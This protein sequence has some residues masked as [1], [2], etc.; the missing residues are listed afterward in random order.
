LGG[1]AK[2]IFRLAIARHD[3]PWNI[4][5]IFTLVLSVQNGLSRQFRVVYCFSFHSSNFCQGKNY[6]KQ[7]RR[8]GFLDGR[9]GT[10]RWVT[11]THSIV[12]NFNVRYTSERYTATSEFLM[13]LV[14]LRLQ[15]AKKWKMGHSA[16]CTAHLIFATQLQDARYY[17]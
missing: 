16:M 9:Y 12:K 3:P 8:L 7:P 4:L 10:G 11:H 2:K 14:L 6:E 1:R 13:I 5:L 15:H 17:Y